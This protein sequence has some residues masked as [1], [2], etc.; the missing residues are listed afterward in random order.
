MILKGVNHASFLTGEVPKYLNSNDLKAEASAEDSQK[1]VADAVKSFI[2]TGIPK[3]DLDTAAF[4]D[5]LYQSMLME[6]YEQFKPPCYDSNI[7]NPVSKLCSAGS[8]WVT[9]VAHNM[10]ADD[11]HFKN[12]NVKFVNHDEFHRADSVAPYHHPEVIS[13]CSLED[14]NCTFEAYSVNQNTYNDVTDFTK[15]EKF[16]V[17]AWEQRSK[18]KARQTLKIKSGETDADFHVNDEVGSRCAEIN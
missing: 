4:L 8:P 3:D 10:M 6:G 7:V 18:M 14:K 16:Q 1:A 2:A 9:Q 17:A 13:S 5:P 12:M 15:L 11:H